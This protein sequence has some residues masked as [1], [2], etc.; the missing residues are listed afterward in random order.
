MD[1]FLEEVVTKRDRILDDLAYYASWAV[2]VAAGFMALMELSAVLSAITSGI[3]FLALVPDL[4]LGLVSAAIAVYIFLRHDRLRTEYEYT[5][6]NGDL[7]FAQVYNNSKRK[8]L[9]SLKIRNVDAC[10]KVSGSAFQRYI[11]MPNVKQSRWFLNRG[12][13]L[14]FF[15]FQK[16]DNKRVI[17]AEPS[18]EMMGM[19]KQ[20][21]PHGA[22]Q[23]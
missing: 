21:L 16:D 17:I 7:D 5:F 12:A 3:A 9:G 6:T 10:G 2:L 15:Y 13:E 1:H 18:E 8:S 14:Y 11:S 20:Y 19:V 4:V 23:E 22:W